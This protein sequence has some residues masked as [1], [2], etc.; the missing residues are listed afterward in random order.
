MARPP[1]RWRDRHGGGARPR[2]RRGRGRDAARRD[3]RRQRRCHPAPA[4]SPSTTRVRFRSPGDQNR[5][6]VA[7]R[8]AAFARLPSMRRPPTAPGRRDATN[9]DKEGACARPL[10]APTV[11]SGASEALGLTF[12]RHCRRPGRRVGP[13]S[14]PTHPLPC[15]VRDFRDERRQRRSRPAGSGNSSAPILTFGRPA[16]TGQD[17]LAATRPTRWPESNPLLAAVRRRPPRGGPNSV[18]TPPRASDTAAA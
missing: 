13:S 12:D 8:P 3:E 2:S 5:S 6:R 9:R 15:A 4:A 14:R 1:R 11:N 10:W 18:S 7:D 17:R 16:T